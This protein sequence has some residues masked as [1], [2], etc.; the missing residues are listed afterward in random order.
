MRLTAVIKSAD[1]PLSKLKLMDDNRT[2][3]GTG[4]PGTNAAGHHVDGPGN[5]RLLGIHCK[6]VIE[7][8]SC[9]W[10][11]LPEAGLHR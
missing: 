2:M 9:N 8:V 10:S 11:P 3:F 1:K 7:T 6:Q 5:N 4:E